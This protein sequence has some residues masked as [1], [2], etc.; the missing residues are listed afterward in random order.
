MTYHAKTVWS[1]MSKILAQNWYP[2]WPSVHSAV[3]PVPN[4]FQLF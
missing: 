1:S 3:M 2:H 4:L